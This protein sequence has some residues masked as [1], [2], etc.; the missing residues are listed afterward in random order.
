MPYQNLDSEI[1][2][3]VAI[4]LLAIFI[5]VAMLV[6]AFVEV[7]AEYRAK[8]KL[9][10]KAGPRRWESFSGLAANVLQRM[11]GIHLSREKE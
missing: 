4:W 11:K 9:Q 2:L 6:A 7:L 1:M 3:A 10:S 5:F 8:K